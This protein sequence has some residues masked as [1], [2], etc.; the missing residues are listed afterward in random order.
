ML[1]QSTRDTQSGW[2]I[3][4]EQALQSIRLEPYPTKDNPSYYGFGYCASIP[5]GIVIPKPLYEL[6]RPGGV[7][8]V[9][10]KYKGDPSNGWRI[11]KELLSNNKWGWEYDND[12]HLSLEEHI[13]RGD[14]KGPIIS[15]LIP[16]KKKAK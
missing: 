6:R 10:S 11:A 15:I 14:G 16:V 4:D 7:Y 13:G 2:R 8:A 12:R 9:I 1:C 5:E 3:Y